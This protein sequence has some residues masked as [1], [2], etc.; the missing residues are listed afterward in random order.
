MDFIPM[1]KIPKSIIFIRK[2]NDN[3]PINGKILSITQ[4]EKMHSQ[5]GRIYYENINPWHK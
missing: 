2:Y 3:K 1:P 4:L 5:T